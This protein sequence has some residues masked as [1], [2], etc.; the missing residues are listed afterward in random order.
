MIYESFSLEIKTENAAFD[1]G[2]CAAEV[3]RILRTVS[4]MVEAGIVGASI[5]DINGNTVGEW[6]FTEDMDA[7]PNEVEEL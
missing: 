3:S 5:R 6:S 4:E 2:N 7:E 1:D